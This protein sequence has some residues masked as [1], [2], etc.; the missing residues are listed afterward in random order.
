M[1]ILTRPA[2]RPLEQVALFCAQVN[3]FTKGDGSVSKLFKT[4]IALLNRRVDN[5]DVE[6]QGHYHPRSRILALKS[7]PWG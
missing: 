7:S 6:V 4:L 1:K 5:G 3:S 2:P